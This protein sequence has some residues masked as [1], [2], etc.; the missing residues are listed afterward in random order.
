MEFLAVLT[1]LWASLAS[2]LSSIDWLSIGAFLAATGGLGLLGWVW[3]S[4]TAIAAKLPWIGAALE[5]LEVVGF[6]PTA[7]REWV[8]RRSWYRKGEAETERLVSELSSPSQPPPPTPPAALGL[9]LVLLGG[10]I[11]GLLGACG[12]PLPDSVC[13]LPTDRTLPLALSLARSAVTV[14]IDTCSPSCPEP[15]VAAS[16]SLRRADAGLAEVCS[17]VEIARTVPCI[18][19]AAHLDSIDT[20]AGCAH[21]SP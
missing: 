15:L 8:L 10:T 17:A 13:G 19:C 5:L 14:A 11:C 20:L 3:R 16:E 9:L 6:S 21:D 1:S 7:L 12:G 18:Q 4:R 2:L